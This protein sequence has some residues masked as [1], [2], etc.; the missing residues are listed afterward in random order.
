M[1]VSGCGKS[2]IGQ[3]LAD[4]F[5]LRFVDADDHH[6]PENIAK[7]AQGIAL[8]DAERAPWL[9]ALADVLAAHDGIVL[10]CSALKRRYRNRLS[11]I[12]GEPPVFIHLHGHIDALEARL[13]ARTGHYFTGRA[14]LE[15]Q[16]AALEPPGPDEAI[17]VRVD[18]VDSDG[19]L[20]RCVARLQR[21]ARWD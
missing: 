19:V 5:G 14:M 7:M 1:G 11:S 13:E 10:A 3:A 4:R 12:D 2:V 21:A 17:P 6:S 20:N 9:A 18:D 15:S 8:T 16:Y